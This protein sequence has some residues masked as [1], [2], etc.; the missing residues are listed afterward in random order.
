MKCLKFFEKWSEWTKNSNFFAS[1]AYT[2]LSHHFE[3]SKVIP[4]LEL[5]ILL[6]WNYRLKLE[7]S[8]K[9][10]TSL[11]PYSGYYQS[12]CFHQNLNA[13]KNYHEIEG[14]REWMPPFFRQNCFKKL[15]IRMQ[16]Q[17]NFFTHY[18]E[19]SRQIASLNC[20]TPVLLEF[21]MDFSGRFFAKDKIHY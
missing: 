13:F 15:W 4:R 6:Y 9:H 12:N 20:I 17:R 14:I 1:E 2:T 5:I 8:Y 21:N 11:T 19:R 10:W 18:S 3:P 16:L 7:C